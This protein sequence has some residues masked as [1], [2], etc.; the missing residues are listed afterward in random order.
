MTEIYRRYEEQ[1]LN[2][3]EAVR[4]KLN[5][6]TE[7]LEHFKEIRAILSECEKNIKLMQT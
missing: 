3:F 1:F 4:T 2:D 7:T 6:P 5:E